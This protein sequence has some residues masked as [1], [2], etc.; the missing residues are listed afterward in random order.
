MEQGVLKE[1]KSG[2]TN[3]PIQLVPKPDETFRLVT[4]YK[5][6]NR[7]TYPDRCYVINTRDTVERLN[8]GIFFLSKLHLAN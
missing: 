6:L 1:I 8:D 7:V 4:N 5:A 2:I 3:S